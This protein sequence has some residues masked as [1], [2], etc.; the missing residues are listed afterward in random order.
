MLFVVYLRILTKR[1][2][3]KD[4]AGPNGYLHIHQHELY[5]VNLDTIGFG[6][7]NF[8]DILHKTAFYVVER[9]Y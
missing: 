1:A 6:D 4:I 3:N 5:N 9:Q 7:T 2:M 8:N